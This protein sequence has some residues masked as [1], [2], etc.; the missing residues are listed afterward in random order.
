MND[1]GEAVMYE[2]NTGTLLI[3]EGT[4]LPKSLR[5]ESEHYSN[6]WAAITN[7]RSEFNSEVKQAGWTFF[8]MA[9]D[10]RATVFG[11]DRDKAVHTAIERIITNVKSQK[12]NCLEIIQVTMKSFLRV[13]YVS[14]SAHSRHIQK[15]MTFSSQ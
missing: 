11:F 5:L 1:S 4:A 8:F 10:I 3:E 7:V 14:V 12:C 9:G 6:G 2:I 13:P 15:S